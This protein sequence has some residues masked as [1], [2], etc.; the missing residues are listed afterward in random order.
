M[1]AVVDGKG[2]G[3]GFVEFR[4][5]GGVRQVEGGGG[6]DFGSI[7]FRAL[8]GVGLTENSR[9]NRGKKSRQEQAERLGGS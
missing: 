7:D 3:E 1:D 5:F 4:N 8:A 2:L 9:G 6:E